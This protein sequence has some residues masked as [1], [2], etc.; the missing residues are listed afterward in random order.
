M[1]QALMTGIQR[2]VKLLNAL[3][4]GVEHATH[5]TTPQNSILTGRV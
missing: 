3:N 2:Q 1:A 5:G 4:Y